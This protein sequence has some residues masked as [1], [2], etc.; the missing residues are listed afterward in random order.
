MPRSNLAYYAIRFGIEAFRQD[1]LLLIV[2]TIRRLKDCEMRRRKSCF[3]HFYLYGTLLNLAILGLHTNGC[4]LWD[5]LDIYPPFSYQDEQLPIDKV[6]AIWASE[7]A[8]CCELC[9]ERS[10][11]NCVAFVF[12]VNFGCAFR[13][14]VITNTANRPLVVGLVNG[15]LCLLFFHLFL[16]GSAIR[17]NTLI[18]ADLL[19]TNFNV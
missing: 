13:S 6:P 15:G 12:D 1:L 10:G 5:G 17:D 9:K 3:A 19:R 16:S 18:I 4:E 8:A 14:Q 7:P 2:K 11:E